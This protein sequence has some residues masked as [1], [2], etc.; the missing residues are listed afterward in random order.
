MVQFK[1]TSAVQTII[2]TNCGHMCGDC[3]ELVIDNVRLYS[4]A[5]LAPPYQS[6]ITATNESEVDP[7]VGIYPNPFQNLI[8]LYV[9]QVGNYTISL[10]DVQ[11]RVLM[12]Q[13]GGQSVDV[14]E[15]SRGIFFIKI[16]NGKGSVVRQ[17][18]KAF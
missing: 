8:H 9:P 7:T 15:L 16:E 3:T 2:F 4:L 10:L 14:S 1:A 6:C 18:V 11:G 12:V 13:H 5:E 17:V